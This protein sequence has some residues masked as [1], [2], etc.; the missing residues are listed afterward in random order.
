MEPDSSPLEMEC[1]RCGRMEPMRF[2]GICR[3]CRARLQELFARE[4]RAIEVPDY[5]PPMHVTPNA[6]A[7]RG[8]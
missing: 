8:D 2:Y 4:R 6:V 3:G 7:L 1:M 5:E